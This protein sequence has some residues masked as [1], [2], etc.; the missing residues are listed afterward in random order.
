MKYLKDFFTLGKLTVSYTVEKIF[1]IG[2]LFIAYKAY[3]FGKII[4][5]TH[6]YSK[7]SSYLVNGQRLIIHANNLPLGI[8]GSL[9]FFI[10]SLIIWKLVCELLIKFFSYFENKLGE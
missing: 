5:M 7:M 6:T 9:L 2:I 3:L 8:I 10:V 4:Y 1:Y